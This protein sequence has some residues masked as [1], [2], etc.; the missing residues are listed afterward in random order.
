[1]AKDDRKKQLG[2]GIRALL[3]NM[4]EQPE[5]RET[6]VREISKHV[7]QVPIAWIELNP[8]QPRKDFDDESLKNLA[9][10][11]KV[12]GI[13]QPLTLRR[14]SDEAYQ[15]ISGERR[16]RAS[17]MAGLDSVPAYI[18]LADDQGMLE[19]A[20]VENIQREDLNALEVAISMNRL[21]SEC[22]LTHEELSDRLGK[23]RSTVTNYLRLLKLPPEIQRAVRNQTISM[24]HARALAGVEDLPRQLLLFRQV[25]EHGWSVRKL[26]QVLRSGSG[27]PVPRRDTHSELP[28]ELRVIQDELSGKF[29]SKVV[30]KRSASGKG[31]LTIHFTSDR[32]LNQILDIL[33]E[34]DD[35][36]S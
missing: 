31:T 1:M 12:H 11:I 25:V 33:Q 26:E 19:M 6:V 8:H 36:N 32:N 10:S 30:F 34:N 21:I 22:Q 16:L 20:L 7:E 4:D 35:E 15:L 3:A 24:G 5:Q 9:Q 14:L 18:R 29:G 23:D 2:K 17:K 28:S 27:T 13:I